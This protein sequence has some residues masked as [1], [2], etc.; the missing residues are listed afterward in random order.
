MEPR[1]LN[2]LNTVQPNM[3]DMMAPI[4]KRDVNNSAPE[5]KMKPMRVESAVVWPSKI[6]RTVDNM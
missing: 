5:L 4:N 1:R 3:M 6:D 2:D